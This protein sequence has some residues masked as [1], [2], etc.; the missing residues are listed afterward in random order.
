MTLRTYR[1]VNHELLRQLALQ[2]GLPI[3]VET[4]RESE[5]KGGV[6]NFTASKRKSQKT[7]SMH[8]DDPRLL[9]AVVN[10]LRDHKQLKI[11]RPERKRELPDRA[12]FVHESNIEGT[13]VYLPVKEGSAVPPGIEGLTV[14]V[15]EPIGTQIGFIDSEADGSWAWDWIGTYLFIVEEH[16]SDPQPKYHFSG[17]SALRLLVDVV[18]GHDP[19]VRD[20]F[21]EGI[22]EDPYGRDNSAHPIDKLRRVGGVPMR[23]RNVEIVYRI[24]LMTDEQATTINGEQIRLNDILAYP[25]YIADLH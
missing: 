3:D 1:V 23:P 24:G 22:T 17:I 11:Y 15:F 7:S 19:R 13:P 5:V 18:A 14:W 21:Y 25:L 10:G 12:T 2:L 9:E 20:K 4:E 8:L 16:F 6:A